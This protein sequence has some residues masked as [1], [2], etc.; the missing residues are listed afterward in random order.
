[1]KVLL[2]QPPF[3]IYHSESKKCHP[4]LGLAYLAGVL[5]F[6]YDVRILDALAEGYDFQEKI[7]PG[8]IRYGMA[9]TE[10]RKRIADFSPDIV[11]VSCLFSAQVENSLVACRAA[12]EVS[13][14]ILTVSG[15]AHPSTVP[16]EMLA[17]SN[18]DFIVLQEGETSF[19]ALLQALEAKSDFSR[20]DGIAFGFKI[21]FPFFFKAITS[22]LEKSLFA[23]KACSNA[24]KLVSPSCKTIKSKLESASISCGTVEGW[25]P[26]DTVRMLLETSL[27]A[28]Q[29]KREFSTCAENKHDTPTISGEKSAIRFLISVKAIP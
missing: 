8:I 12:K 21:I 28:L 4:P 9:F 19:P 5:R 22:I 13:K 6:N 29:A 17:D 25:A 23:S 10:I 11:G 16:Q 24:G 20:I 3:T 1:M 2:I 15:G 18:L 14:S 27:A 7:S 26:P